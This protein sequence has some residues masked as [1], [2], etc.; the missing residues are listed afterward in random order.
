MSSLQRNLLL[1]NRL[2]TVGDPTHT[3]IDLDIVNNS[4]NYQPQPVIFQQTNLSNI[5]D[6]I[7]DYYMSVVKWS[8][9]ANIPVIIPKMELNTTGTPVENF[10]SNTS[11]YINIGYGEFI[12][13]A[14]FNNADAE[15]VIFQP[16]NLYITTP[17]YKPVSQVDVNSNEYYYIYSVDNFL[18]MVNDAIELVFNKKKSQYPSLLEKAVSPIFVWNVETET[19]KLI[20]SNEFIQG[21]NTET[22]YI[23]F[24][25]DLYNL[26]DTFPSKC[27]NFTNNPIY[28]N[29]FVFSI[30]N[31][32]DYNSIQF[33]SP[34]GTTNYILLYTF[35]QQSSSVPSWSPVSNIVFTT[36]SMAINPEISGGTQYLGQD[37]KNINAVQ[38]VILSITD[39][40]IPMQSGVEYSRALL[41]YIPSSEYRLI[42]GMSNSS[43]NRITMQ[44]FWKDKLNFFHFVN[45]KQGANASVKI[46]F[47]KKSFNGI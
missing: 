6:K 17:K 10:D 38:N 25:T 31:M 29:N 1:N 4:T 45:L 28:G 13:N 2:N 16:E 24:N 27:L 18:K 19:I 42:D 26:F 9:N 43:L 37:L 14:T 20:V 47:R 35:N 21:M 11:Y 46:M 44:I 5:V 36:N 41:Y 33:N 3:Y 12:S 30:N 40:T 22:F 8:F 32:Y 15:C 7:D 23:S 34:K 39:F